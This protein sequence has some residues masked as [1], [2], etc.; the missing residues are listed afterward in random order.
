[1]FLLSSYFIVLDSIWDKYT[2]G[3]LKRES[4]VIAVCCFL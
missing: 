2:S 1:M 3:T 4:A